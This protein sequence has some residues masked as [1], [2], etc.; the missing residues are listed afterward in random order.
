MPQNYLDKLDNIRWTIRYYRREYAKAVYDRSTINKDR[1]R[2]LICL[3]L[4]ELEL[5][6]E[7]E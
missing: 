4:T 1:Y 2:G 7:M 5:L 6:G 3:L